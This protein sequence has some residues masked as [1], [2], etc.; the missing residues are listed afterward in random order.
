MDLLPTPRMQARH[1]QNYSMIFHVYSRETPTKPAFKPRD[2]SVGARSQTSSHDSHG[3]G[4]VKSE[5]TVEETR[6]RGIPIS[7]EPGVSEQ[8]PKGICC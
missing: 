4:S 1:H 7:T 3:D 2:S 8:F 6:L 5:P